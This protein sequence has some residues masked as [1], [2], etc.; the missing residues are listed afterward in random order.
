MVQLV[1]R[2][3]RL[4]CGPRRW[5]APG[6]R[7]CR[8]APAA[9]EVGA[10]SAERAAVG[11]EVMALGRDRAAGFRRPA[12]RRLRPRSARSSTAPALMRLTLP[13]MKASGL[14]HQQ[15]DQHL[16]ERDVGRL[17]GG[18]DLAGGVTARCTVMLFAFAARRSGRRRG[19]ARR[20]RPRTASPVPRGRRRRRGQSAARARDGRRDAPGARQAPR[21]AARRARSACRHA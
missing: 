9:F 21:P 5:P 11:A 8:S 2:G 7:R 4:R 1:G 14:A 13:P 3:G 10:F 20:R 12:P 19:E 6:L 18:C 16:V 15:R 17:V